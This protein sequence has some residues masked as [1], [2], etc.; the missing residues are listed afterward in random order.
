MVLLTCFSLMMSVRLV[1]FRFCINFIMDLLTSS[2]DQFCNLNS[3]TLLKEMLEKEMATNFSI[4]VWEIPERE[5]WRV[6]VYGG[7]KESDMTWQLNRNNTTV[8]RL[9][10]SPIL[11]VFSNQLTSVFIEYFN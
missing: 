9:L 6:T 7:C 4:L 8:L 11:S 1:S 3:S 10:L 2:K 5:T